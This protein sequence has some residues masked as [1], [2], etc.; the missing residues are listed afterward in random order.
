MDKKIEAMVLE[1]LEKAIK[2]D[3]DPINILGGEL[4]IVKER[5]G[6]DGYVKVVDV[7]RIIEAFVESLT[8][9]GRESF[10]PLELQLALFT[11][12]ADVAV[13]GEFVSHAVYE[14]AVWERNT[15]I[16]QL[17][18]YGVGLGEDADVAPVVHAITTDEWWEEIY[19]KW[20]TCGNCKGENVFAAEYCNWCG[21]RLDG[22]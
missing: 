21:A 14:Q 20:K 4:K 2:G 8:V 6:P 12:I 10:T 17:E 5:M 15:A 16:E 1:H 19:C 11:L 13:D 22:E 7:F 3:A 9:K 18:S